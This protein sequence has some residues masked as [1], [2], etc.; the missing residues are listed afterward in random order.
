ME[1]LVLMFTVLYYV[2]GSTYV[3]VRRE[4]SESSYKVFE[5]GLFLVRRHFQIDQFLFDISC[6]YMENINISLK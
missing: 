4:I 6:Q 1:V 5:S 2:R 3:L